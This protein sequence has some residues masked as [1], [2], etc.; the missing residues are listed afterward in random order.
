MSC[1][2]V[3]LALTSGA[4]LTGRA[5]EHAAVCATCRASIDLD[6]RLAGDALPAAPPMSAALRLALD[7]PRSVEPFS[8]WAR[9]ALPAAVTLAAFALVAG[10]ALR[11]DIASAPAWVPPVLALGFLGSF[12]AGLHL[13][14][15][16][17]RSGMAA[18]PPARVVFLAL[19]AATYGMLTLLQAHA[20]EGPQPAR[21]FQGWLAEHLVP[22][23]GGWVRHL[24]CSLLGLFGGAAI[25]AGA[26]HAARRTA[27]ARP[28]LAGAVAGAAAAMATAFVL[29]SFC[30]S[31]AWWHVTLVHAAPLLG[32]VFFGAWAGRRHLAP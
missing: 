20:F 11:P 24:P 27:V 12:A 8:P 6:A 5:R 31:R 22:T 26:L 17:D 30:S 28:A 2:E 25:V 7:A 16:R 1:D 3:L 32:L 18:A 23:A 13:L 19:A 9:A 10:L 4:P 14:L 29:F 21:A 15:R